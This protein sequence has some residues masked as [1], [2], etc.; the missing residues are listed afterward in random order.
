MNLARI[1]H[2]IITPIFIVLFM[3]FLTFNSHGE[4]EK[5]LPKLIDLGAKGCLPC[6]LM[7]PILKELQNE[8]AGSLIVEVYDIHEKPEIGRKYNVRFI[9]TQIFYDR[10][11]KELYRHIG[12]MSKK[13]ILN[14]FER[15][16]II[17]KK[18]PQKK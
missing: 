5:N 13:D 6:K 12:F 4:Q 3:L 16:G 8:Y 10:H 11:G 17:L 15:F 9:P 14:T 18:T 1:K 2:R 7:K